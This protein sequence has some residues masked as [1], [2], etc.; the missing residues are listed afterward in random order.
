MNST[1]LTFPLYIW[2]LSAKIWPRYVQHRQASH[3]SVKLILHQMLSREN[4]MDV[5]LCKTNF[6]LTIKSFDTQE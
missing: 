4:L 2:K 5:I 1:F 3:T 6:I